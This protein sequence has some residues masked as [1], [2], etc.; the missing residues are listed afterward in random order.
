ML[1]VSPSGAL[2]RRSRRLL[3]I[4][5]VITLAGIFIGVVGL[6][7]YVVPLTSKTSS[8]YTT[9]NLGRGVLFLGGGGLAVTGI[10]M[11]VRAAT[12]KRENPLAKLAGDVLQRH[13]DSQYAFIRNINK[14]E[15]GYIDAVLV[16]PAGVLV[17]RVV[18]YEGDFF[19]EAARW[20]RAD[21]R[22]RWKPA[23][24]DPTCEAV[25]DIKSLRAYLAARG[26]PD[27]PVFGVVVFTK[28]DPIVRLSL[29][30]PVMPAT[31]L[32]SLYAR[33]QTSYLD[34]NRIEKPVVDAVV[35][36]LYDR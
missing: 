17:F 2:A 11:A 12:W 28:D 9:F 31:H 20:M 3:E 26:L 8:L 30:D 27:I 33:L 23:R 6:A 7:L 15:V 34:K 1:H 21:K 25:A 24:I 36:L 19:N 29:K 13:L 4:A 18:D 32:S 14:R 22:G 16:G 35:R 10:I 5:F